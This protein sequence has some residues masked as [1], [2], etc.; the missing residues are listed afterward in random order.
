MFSA[1]DVIPL[2]HFE[3][4]TA[5]CAQVKHE[6]ARRLILTELKG[7]RIAHVSVQL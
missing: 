4:Y 6:G 2:G 5:V 1:N 7:K 3:S